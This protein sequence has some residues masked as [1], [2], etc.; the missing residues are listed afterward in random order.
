[1]RDGSPNLAAAPD[2]PDTRRGCN[3]A[4]YDR[5]F[6]V[7]AKGAWDLAILRSHPSGH[8][9]FGRLRVDQSADQSAR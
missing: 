1:M 3:E 8:T 7:N 6:G 2:G 5:V 9:D 4:D